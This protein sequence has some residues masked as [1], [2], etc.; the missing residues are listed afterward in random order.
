MSEWKPLD[1]ESIGKVLWDPDIRH[2]WSTGLACSCGREVIV[3]WNDESRE[4]ACGRCFR[5]VLQVEEW[6]ADA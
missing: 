5:V 1:K 4:C 6:I 3:A 2:D